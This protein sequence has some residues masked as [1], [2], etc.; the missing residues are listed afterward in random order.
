MLFILSLCKLRLILPITLCTICL[1]MYTGKKP[2]ADLKDAGS[3]T[4]ECEVE[5]EC[6]ILR[7]LERGLQSDALQSV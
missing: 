7:V 1:A 3:L 4:V 2:G 6:D 5:I